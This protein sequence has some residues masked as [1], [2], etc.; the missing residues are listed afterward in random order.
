MDIARIRALSA[1]K[2]GVMGVEIGAGF[3]YAVIAVVTCHAVI[4]IVDREHE[5]AQLT[6]ER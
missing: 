4:A 5:L 6:G 2:H 1:T 3:L